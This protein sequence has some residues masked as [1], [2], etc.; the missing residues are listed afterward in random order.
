[1]NTSCFLLPTAVR[2]LT[3]S[4]CSLLV[5]IDASEIKAT[6]SQAIKNIVLAAE[7]LSSRN[8][9]KRIRTFF[10]LLLTYRILLK[11]CPVGDTSRCKKH[12]E[13]Y[14]ILE[15]IT[16]LLWANVG[17]TLTFS[18]FSEWDRIFNVSL[19]HAYQQIWCET[20]DVM[21]GKRWAEGQGKK[22]SQSVTILL[23]PLFFLP[24]SLCKLGDNVS[25]ERKALWLTVICQPTAFNKKYFREDRSCGAAWHRRGYKDV[26]PN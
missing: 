24:A 1:M 18:I 20:E 10:P 2:L 19:L 9:S 17:I 4:I 11:W 23:F 25:K 22:Q 12:K 8:F 21:E 3:F 5:S 7:S 16:S 13:T 15:Q 6:S 26:N 14:V